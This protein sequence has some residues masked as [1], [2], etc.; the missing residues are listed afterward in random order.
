VNISLNVLKGTAEP[1]HALCDK[2]AE[3]DMKNVPSRIEWKD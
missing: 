1:S 3:S 2:A